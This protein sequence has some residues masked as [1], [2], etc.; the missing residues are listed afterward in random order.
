M[1]GVYDI[2][3]G[4]EWKEDTVNKIMKV[5]NIEVFER[6][7]P[8][9]L[10]MSKMYD[11]EDVKN[12]FEVCRTS[13]GNYNFSLI[14]R[15]RMLITIVYNEKL[16]RLDLPIKKYMESVYRFTEEHPEGALKEEI[17]KFIS[18]FANE[19]AAHAS[20]E[21]IKILMAPGAMK[22]IND[23]LLKIFRCMIDMGRPARTGKN[24][25]VMKLER[26]DLPWVDKE[27]KEIHKTSVEDHQLY[28]IG[29]FLDNLQIKTLDVDVNTILNN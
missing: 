19:Y 22:I 13:T 20:T 15:M 6:V 24:K 5:K 26:I 12:I 9:F 3:K 25:G 8:L 28:F 17:F 1:R 27:T 2:Q 4:K 29:E 16:R 21:T 18:D 10:S 7:I 23:T 11:V 14:Q